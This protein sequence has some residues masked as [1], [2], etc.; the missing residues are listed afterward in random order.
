MYIVRVH[1]DVV[2]MLPFQCNTP[3][4]LNMYIHRFYKLVFFFTLHIDLSS[5]DFCLLHFPS[6][7]KQIKKKTGTKLKTTTKNTKQI[8]STKHSLNLHFPY[9]IPHRQLNEMNEFDSFLMVQTNFFHPIFSASFSL[10][11]LHI[12]FDPFCG[13]I[14]SKPEN[15]IKSNQIK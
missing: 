2:V 10:S 11:L 12:V 8:K 9:S 15:K 3:I 1:R 14:F 13:Y 7:L 4:D 5:I 6:F